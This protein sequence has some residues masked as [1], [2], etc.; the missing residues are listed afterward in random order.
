M[1]EEKYNWSRANSS[2]FLTTRSGTSLSA[3]SDLEWGPTGIC[4]GQGPH[5]PYVNAY[6][7]LGNWSLCIHPDKAGSFVF[8]E[9]G[10]RGA[11]FR[12]LK[13]S[14]VFNGKW[15]GAWL[16]FI[17]AATHVARR[18]REALGG[19]ESSFGTTAVEKRDKQRAKSGVD[20]RLDESG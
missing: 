6:L 10:R 9:Q 17:S 2:R 13:P 11:A 4:S 7:Y 20:K 12:N 3:E 14:Y 5:P 8:A 16:N 1:D 18:A 15:R 19:F